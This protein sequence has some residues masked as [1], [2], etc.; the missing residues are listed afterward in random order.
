ML[1]FFSCSKKWGQ[2]CNTINTNETIINK[3]KKYQ[4]QKIN[5]QQQQTKK[6]INT[7]I[8]L[9]SIFAIDGFNG[10]WVG[11][12]QMGFRVGGDMNGLVFCKWDLGL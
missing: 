7:L 3:N 9:I 10:G 1:L 12:L 2:I 5:P 8:Y 6:K 4:Q 11:F